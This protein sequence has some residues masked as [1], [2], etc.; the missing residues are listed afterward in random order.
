MAN[1]C[2]SCCEP[3]N[4]GLVCGKQVCAT[5]PRWRLECEASD[6]LRRH[7]SDRRH[8]LQQVEYHRGKIAAAELKQV[9]LDLWQKNS[10]REAG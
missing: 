6:L 1:D 9:I 4:Q 8:Y 2:D 7:L 3:K 10:R 5:C